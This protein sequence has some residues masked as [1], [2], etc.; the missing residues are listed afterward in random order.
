MTRQKITL[1]DRLELAMREWNDALAGLDD[2]DFARMVYHKWNLKDVLGHVLAY[3]DLTLRHVRAYKKRKRLAS[4]RAPSY[5][6][7]NRREAERLRD[8]P[9]AQ[10]R[11]NLDATHRELIA[12][13]PTLR[14]DDLKKEFPAQ[15]TNSKYKTTLRYQLRENTAHLRIHAREVSAWR[16]REKIKRKS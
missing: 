15:W 8:V 2:A 11:A 12:L 16:K 9:L 4:P 7:F 6:Y 10:L 3:L 5:A 13:I 14:D 1:T